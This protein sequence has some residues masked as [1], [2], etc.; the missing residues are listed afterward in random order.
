LSAI[1]PHNGLSCE[2][3]RGRVQERF[4]ELADIHAARILACA[5]MI[6]HGHFMWRIDSIAAQGNAE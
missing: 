4:R 2:H 6:K 5:V 1:N 3:R